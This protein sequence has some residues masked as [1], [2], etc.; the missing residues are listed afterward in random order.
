MIP[1][2]IWKKTKLER[3]L[4]GRECEEGL[5]LPGEVCC[6]KRLDSVRIRILT[7]FLSGSFLHLEIISGRG[8]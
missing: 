6:L 3:E 2:R 4:G 7:G 5:W 8:D 1:H